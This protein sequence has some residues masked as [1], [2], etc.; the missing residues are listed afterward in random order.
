MSCVWDD[1][2]LFTILKLVNNLTTLP[3]TAVFNFKIYTFTILTVS[4][5]IKM[6]VIYWY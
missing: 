1:N 3:G 2:H 4:G 6:I 5:G